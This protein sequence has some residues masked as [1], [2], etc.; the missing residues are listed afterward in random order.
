MTAICPV[1]STKP[2]QSTNT[3]NQSLPNMLPTRRLQ[4]SMADGFRGWRSTPHN[5]SPQRGS[6][7]SKTLLVP[8]CTMPEQ[9]TQHFLPHSVPLQ[10]AKAMAQGQW[11]MRVT[12]S[13]TTSL[14]IPMQSFGTRRATWYYQ[15]TQMR[16]TYPNPAV[17]VE[18]PIISTSPIAITK[19]ST[20]ALFSPCLPSSNTSCHQPPRLNLLCS[21]MAASLL[22]HF[23]PH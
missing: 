11:R 19:T 5:P 4:S 23:K 14:H 8:S 3:P 1:T 7:M 15:Y 20:M 2:S 16:H 22:P 12:N 6:N 13:L 9:L 21:T 18:Q 17:K 10:H